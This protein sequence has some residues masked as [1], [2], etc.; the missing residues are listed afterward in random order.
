MAICMPRRGLKTGDEAAAARSRL[1]NQC[2]KLIE[3]ERTKKKSLQ[4][5]KIRVPAAR[6]WQETVQAEAQNA[7]NL[8][9]E[10]IGRILREEW[11][12]TRLKLEEDS[13]EQIG[14][15]DIE[16]MLA[17]E[18]EIRTE[19]SVRQTTS[20]SAVPNPTITVDDVNRMEEDT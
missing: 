3:Q 17:L 14:E 16:Q 15:L 2:R 1:R 9:E 7:V 4:I 12:E 8:S 5:E 11:E 19:Q 6:W 13:L 10:T 20:E 18:E